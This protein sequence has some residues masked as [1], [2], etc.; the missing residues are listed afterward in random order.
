MNE[1]IMFKCPNCGKEIQD[2]RYSIVT[3]TEQDELGGAFDICS[4][5]VVYIAQ[6]LDEHPNF[7]MTEA[8]NFVEYISNELHKY[9]DGKRCL[10][11]E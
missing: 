3:P 7:G 4:T 1:K 6:F 5:A 8:H 9:I 10:A 2:D 11:N